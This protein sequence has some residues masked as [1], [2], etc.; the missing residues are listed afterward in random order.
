MTLKNLEDKLYE[1]FLDSEHKFKQQSEKVLNTLSNIEDNIIRNKVFLNESLTTLLHDQL[2]Q[3]EIAIRIFE[4]LST[5]NR[6]QGYD[7]RDE[8][9]SKMMI[10]R[11]LMTLSYELT[12]MNESTSSSQDIHGEFIQEVL[13]ND[14]NSLYY[15]MKYEAPLSA[16]FENYA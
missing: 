16:C 2:Y 15:Y 3:Q 6:L 4:K 1:S 8:M 5:H 10:S 12:A 11:I 9:K 13:K 14:L 7:A